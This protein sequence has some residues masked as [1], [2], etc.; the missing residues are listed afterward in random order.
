MS[1]GVQRTG[2]AVAANAAPGQ[3]EN[4]CVPKGRPPQ[5]ASATVPTA[6]NVFAS[7]TSASHYTRARCG[8]FGPTSSILTGNLRVT[9]AI[10]G[11]NT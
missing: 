9:Q 5:R 7:A 2:K 11:G 10:R 4:R 3:T 6:V 1:P 8:R